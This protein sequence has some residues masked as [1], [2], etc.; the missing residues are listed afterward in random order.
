MTGAKINKKPIKP[1]E[2]Q[3]VN[4]YPAYQRDTSQHNK[5]IDS[6]KGSIIPSS[7]A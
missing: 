2:V 7:D 5:S 6:Y 4:E 3:L 1:V